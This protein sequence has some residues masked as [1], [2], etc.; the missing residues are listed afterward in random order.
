[1]KA[2]ITFKDG[3]IAVVNGLK[4]VNKI[5]SQNSTVTKIEKFDEFH[6]YH[7]GYVFV[8]EKSTLSINGQDILYVSFDS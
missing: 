5:S 8:S 4:H 1:M 6:I 7:T 2:E 3:K